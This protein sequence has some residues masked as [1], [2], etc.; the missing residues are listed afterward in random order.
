MFEGSVL[1]ARLLISLAAAALDYHSMC[2]RALISVEPRAASLRAELE[3][4][5]CV[6][7]F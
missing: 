1:L 6:L 2:Q 3:L 7:G 5:F 4:G